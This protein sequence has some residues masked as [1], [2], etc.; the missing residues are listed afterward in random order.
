[1]YVLWQGQREPVNK[2]LDLTM[3]M[4]DGSVAKGIVS[5]VVALEVLDVVTDE[6]VVVDFQAYVL[7][8]L[9]DVVLVQTVVSNNTH[10]N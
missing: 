4:D 5:Q 10:T 9:R 7:Q 6:V 3:G 8:L 2:F 1:M